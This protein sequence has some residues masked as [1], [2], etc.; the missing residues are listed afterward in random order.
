M[1][2]VMNLKNSRILLIGLLFASLGLL[3]VPVN[4]QAMHWDQP[5]RY[6]TRLPWEFP[7][8][9]AWRYNYDPSNHTFY[10]PKLRGVLLDRCYMTQ[11]RCSGV[12]AAYEF[13]RKRGYR[14][15]H[16]F[17]ILHKVYR[18]RMMGNKQICKKYR[19]NGYRWIRCA[20]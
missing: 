1:S 16:S 5:E 17:S 12:K 14:T 2:T 8:H 18:T 7:Y 15:V 3:F 9:E 10:Y 13:C 4:A 20:R 19:C 6:D 11:N